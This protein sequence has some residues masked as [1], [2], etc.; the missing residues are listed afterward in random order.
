MIYALFTLYFDFFGDCTQVWNVIYYTVQYC[1]AGS[2]ALYF[3][4]NGS[5]SRMPYLIVAAFFYTLMLFELNMLR[6]DRSDYFLNISNPEPLL[7]GGIVFILITIL[8][9]T[10]KKWRL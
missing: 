4:F 3:V 1:F 2:V 7:S 6:L 8:L 5:L 10:I 9:M